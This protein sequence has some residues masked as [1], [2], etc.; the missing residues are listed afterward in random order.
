[1][2]PAA[3]ICVE[4]DS[5]HPIRRAACTRTSDPNWQYLSLKPGPASVNGMKS[6]QTELATSDPAFFRDVFRRIASHIPSGVAVVAGLDARE[7]PFGL[8]VSSLTPASVEPPLV[9]F[10]VRRASC[11][12]A[13][14]HRARRF[15]VN[16]LRRSQQDLAKHFAAADIDRFEGIT[17]RSGDF[18]IPVLEGMLGIMLC[19]LANHVE[20][21]DHEILIAEVKRVLL[22]SGEP[23][24]YW[25]RGLYGLRLEYP[26][27][28]S[29]S[30][31]E[32][33]MRNWKSGT[34]PHHCWTHGAHVA[35]AAYYAFEH[36]PE[37]AF[38]KTKAG[39]VHYNTCVGT[40]NTEDSGYH[41]TL[42]RFWA[43]IIG[44]FVR[45]RAF[46]SRL[47]AARQAVALF[48]EDRDRH[49]LY[50]SFDVVRH[51]R[52]RREWVPPDRVPPPQRTRTQ[53]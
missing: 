45:T 40:A 41:E 3:K 49:R 19:E 43:G 44:D 1:M 20:A 18:G 27:L 11:A 15:S 38:Q 13:N 36:P 16:L 35:V 47:E 34:L 23:L 7:R 33:F 53:A 10:S 31:L 50:Y 51:R 22:G 46:R 17:W 25:R 9:S 52:A 12:W 6:G 32:K 39:I 2:K 4:N 5:F 21:G 30:A 28:E 26:F 14:L 42:T 29:R 48:G 37:V 24:V 8:T